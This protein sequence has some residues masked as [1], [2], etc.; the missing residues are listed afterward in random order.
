VNSKPLFVDQRL[1][2]QQVNRRSV[3]KKNGIGSCCLLGGQD[4]KY[5]Q[6]CVEKR[7]NSRDSVESKAFP[8]SE[9]RY[10]QNSKEGSIKG[11]L[12]PGKVGPLDEKS[13]S[14]PQKCSREHIQK[15]GELLAGRQF[16]GCD[17]WRLRLLV[18]VTY[19]NRPGTQQPFVHEGTCR[20]LHST[21]ESR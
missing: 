10:R 7:R 5:Q 12:K 18:A 17:C 13:A 16:S 4:E 8:A 15:W 11:K 20:T 2:Y 9:K 3:L 1:E 21:V 19:R 6:C 14:T